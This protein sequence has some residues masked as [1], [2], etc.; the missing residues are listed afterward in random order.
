MCSPDRSLHLRDDDTT[1]PTAPPTLQRMSAMFDHLSL[2]PGPAETEWHRAV[3]SSELAAA[4]GSVPLRL[5]L[6]TS[7]GVDP[8]PSSHPASGAWRDAEHQMARAVIDLEEVR[9]EHGTL[10]KN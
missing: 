10:N 5:A 7:A 3:V 9:D 6:R 1:R 2:E 8:E 4:T